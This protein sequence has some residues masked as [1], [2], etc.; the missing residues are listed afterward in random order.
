MASRK[1]STRTRSKFQ[2]TAEDGGS[3]AKK[4]KTD[5]ERAQLP[6]LEEV[7]GEGGV[8]ALEER[9]TVNQEALI[10]APLCESTLGGPVGLGVCTP[11]E[12]I[13]ATISAK[14]EVTGEASLQ[15]CEA[16]DGQVPKDAVNG[17]WDAHTGEPLFVGRAYHSFGRHLVIG[18]IQPS[19]RCIYVPFAG[20][21][22]KYNKYEVLVN[23]GNRVQL[24]W[25]N[26]QKGKVPTEAVQGGFDTT[27]GRE[28]YC[29]GRCSHNGSTLPG[30]IHPS[31]KCLYVS[32][33]GKEI[34]KKEY[35]LLVAIDYYK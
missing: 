28:V 20:G 31:H 8:C 25:V 6:R 17:G 5:T 2:Q 14:Q 18:K 29:I 7:S 4:R 23:P 30:K 27:R 21:E 19:H 24:E 13:G 22:H 9:A 16:V 35:N 33:N 12:S 1:R 10:V 34:S 3:P 32:W 26:S 11:Q 15:W